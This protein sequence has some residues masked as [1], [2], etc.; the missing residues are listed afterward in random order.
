MIRSSLNPAF[1]IHVGDIRF[2]R[3]EAAP[4]SDEI[5]QKINDYFVTFGPQLIYTPG[6][7]EWTDCHTDAG[8]NYDPVERLAKV[9]QLFFEGGKT[10]GANALEVVRQSQVARDGGL[11]ENQRWVYNDIL[12]V[13]AH[14][15][16]SNKD[17][18]HTP[19]RDEEYTARNA[20]NVAWLREAFALAERGNN[21][22]YARKL[23]TA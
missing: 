12:F 22:S 23:V 21:R 14:V 4:C 6:D 7:N 20:A 9:R 1:A 13:T 16:G 10:F 11:I 2:G 8:G 19:E 3:V 18:G 15:V 17:F 5:L